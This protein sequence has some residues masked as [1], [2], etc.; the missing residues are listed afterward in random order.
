MAADDDRVV[1]YILHGK[2]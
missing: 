1:L 2:F